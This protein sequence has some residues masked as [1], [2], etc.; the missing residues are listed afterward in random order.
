MYDGR[1][2]TTGGTASISR[3]V[4]TLVTGKQSIQSWKAKLYE[5]ILR[6][7]RRA[8]TNGLMGTV[9]KL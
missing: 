1:F 5:G 6:F 7:P 3:H 8:L 2:C 9:S 4:T